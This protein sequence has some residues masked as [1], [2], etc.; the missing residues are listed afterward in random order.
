[1]INVISRDADALHMHLLLIIH[2]TPVVLGMFQ[3]RFS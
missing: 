2:H 3:F 1:M